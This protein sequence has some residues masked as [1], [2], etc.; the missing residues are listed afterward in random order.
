MTPLRQELCD[1]ARRDINRAIAANANNDVMK[2]DLCPVRL[3]KFYGRGRS[4][5]GKSEGH[6]SAVRAKSVQ[7]FHH[8][9][10]SSTACGTHR[11]S[12]SFAAVKQALGRVYDIP[13]L[14]CI[15]E[16]SKGRSGSAAVARRALR[17]ELPGACE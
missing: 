9:I 10:R 5:G 6:E 7:P 17:T 16:S 14:D 8:P 3:A 1:A 4:P 2:S 13:W 15:G 12:T 11:S